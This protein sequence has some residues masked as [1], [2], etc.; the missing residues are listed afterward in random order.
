MI[1]RLLITTAPVKRSIVMQF[2]ARL[3]LVFAFFAGTIHA[4]AVAHDNPTSGHEHGS[5]SH[6]ASA[7]HH[8]DDESSHEGAGDSLHHHHC[9]NALNANATDVALGAADGRMILSFRRTTVLTSFSQAPPTE[10][11]AA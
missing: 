5:I 3:M 4:P 2:L 11:P 1:N 9:P 6:D 8:S 7:D 10:P